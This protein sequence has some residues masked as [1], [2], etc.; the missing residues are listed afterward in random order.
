MFEIDLCSRGRHILEDVNKMAK[1]GMEKMGCIDFLVDNAAVRTTA[2]LDNLTE[3][4]WDTALDV[5]PKGMFT[6]CKEF[7]SIMITQGSAS[8]VSISSI[9]GILVNTHALHCF[10]AKAGGVHLTRSIARYLAPEIRVN[11]VASGWLKETGMIPDLTEETL[12]RIGAKTPLRKLGTPADFTEALLFLAASAHFVT[13]QL[14]VV[15]GG[16]TIS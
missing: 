9:G 10:A 14:S 8:I 7:S 4:I 1:S 15:E 13:G 3:G 6:C 11:A 12:N 5:N 2:P 16:I